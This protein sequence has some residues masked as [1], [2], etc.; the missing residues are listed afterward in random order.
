[1]SEIKAATA[2]TTATKQLLAAGQ[3]LGYPSET[4]VRVVKGKYIP[5]V[6][7]SFDGLRALDVG[8]GAGNNLRFLHS[9]GMQVAGTEISEEF[10]GEIRNRLS[11]D[12]IEADLRVGK[13][14]ALPF[15]S[16]S[17]DFLVSWNVI[18]YEDN[19]QAMIAAIREYARVLKPGG[20]LLLSTTG[21]EH[22]ILD[23]GR[24][25]GRHRYEIGRADDFRKGTVY[26]YFDAENYIRHY[27]GM[28][29]D[30]VLTGRT[31]DRL[32]TETLDWFIVT[33]KARH[34]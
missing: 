32:F 4:L 31:H 8:F 17:F 23:G 12:G 24:T 30:E 34:S 14:T 21:P 28:A 5:D 2:W 3:A 16:A 22:K 27:F 20:R 19:E 29:F 7:R 25:L 18:H 33:G 26:F 15:E 10:C 11:E 6:P 13:N 9:L 1:M